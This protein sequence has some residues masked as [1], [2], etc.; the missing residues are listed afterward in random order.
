MQNAHR[1]AVAA[2]EGRKAVAVIDRHLAPGLGGITYQKIAVVL[3][4]SP[5]RPALLSRKSQSVIVLCL[6][7]GIHGRYHRSDPPFSAVLVQGKAKC[8]QP[9]S[10]T[11][12][13]AV[14]RRGR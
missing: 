3:Y 14:L 1:T 11:Q 4:D 2:V 9:A 10:P 8:D 13:I 12:A 5:A 7:I 6:S